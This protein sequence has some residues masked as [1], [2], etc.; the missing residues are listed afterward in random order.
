MQMVEMLWNLT[1][2]LSDA[3]CN[4][5]NIFPLLTKSRNDSVNEIRNF[6]FSTRNDQRMKK[7]IQADTYCEQK[8]MISHRWEKFRFLFNFFFF[9]SS[10]FSSCSCVQIKYDTIVY[11]FCTVPWQWIH[12]DYDIVGSLIHNSFFVSF[13]FSNNGHPASNPSPSKHM[14]TIRKTKNFAQQNSMDFSHF[15]YYDIMCMCALCIH[16]KNCVRK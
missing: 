2:T 10:L 16:W 1:S 11:T 8:S 9:L 7:N 14:H 5:K 4:G 15:H 3:K 13:Y 6:F 12:C